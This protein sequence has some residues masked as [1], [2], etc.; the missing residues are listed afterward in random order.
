MTMS[1]NS[2]KKLIDNMEQK[3]KFNVEITESWFIR[4]NKGGVVFPHNHGGSYSCVYYVQ[5]GKDSK[6]INGSTYFLKPYTAGSNI[7]FGSQTYSTDLTAIMEGQEGKL[8][9]WPSYLYHGS[10]PYS[11]E[12]NRI[13]VSANSKI[14]LITN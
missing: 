10:H 4:Y 3:P 8:V 9:V 11:G 5:I 13:I 7:D 6:K 12:E 14:D 1:N 2:N